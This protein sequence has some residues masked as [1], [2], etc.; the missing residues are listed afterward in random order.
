MAD[1]KT[2][3]PGDRNIKVQLQ[4][5]VHFICP[6]TATVL[7]SSLVGVQP[8]DMYENLWLLYNERAFNECDASLDP[9]RRLL[10]SCNTPMQLKF[11]PVLFAQYTAVPNGLVFEGGWWYYFIG[12]S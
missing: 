1:G 8:A 6:N 3:G 10:L 9:N 5:K 12:K 11:L 2:C 7:E 4:S